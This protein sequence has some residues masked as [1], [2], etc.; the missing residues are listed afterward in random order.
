MTNSSFFI[1]E[2]GFK[3]YNMKNMINWF[4]IPVT[5]F[6]RAKKF[7]EAIL[8]CEIKQGGFGAW[9][10]GL[11]PSDTG[12]VSGALICGKGYEPSPVGALVYFNG[13]PDLSV[14]LARVEAAGGKVTVPK[15][16]ISPEIGYWACVQD[17]EGNRIAFHSQ[18]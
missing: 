2:I 12:M 13:N 15:S 5:D 9:K 18:G 6:E 11:F 8:D 3:Y 7:Y 10:M 1:F 14:N 16:Q 4:E 17:T